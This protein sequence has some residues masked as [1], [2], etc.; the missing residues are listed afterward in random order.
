MT[1]T[2][3][4]LRVALEFVKEQRDAGLDVDYEFDVLSDAYNESQNY[5]IRDNPITQFNELFKSVQNDI[6]EY[7][8]DGL[9]PLEC[10]EY[11]IDKKLDNA[12]EEFVKL[13]EKFC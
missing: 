4:A 5:T 11:D 8:S 1:K 3:N 2:N 10:Y 6:N 9:A 7:L 13:L 12:R